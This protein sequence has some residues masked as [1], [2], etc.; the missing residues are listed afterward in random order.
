MASIEKQ[1]EY[2]RR[3]REKNREYLRQYQRDWTAAHPEARR[4]KQLRLYNLTPEVYDEML[5]RQGYLCA[6]C[7]GAPT[8]RD[9]FFVDHDHVTGKV[10]GLLCHHCNVSIGM[11]KDDPAV[12]EKLAAY[13]RSHKE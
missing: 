6:G 2:Q 7:G 8:A 1:R 9:K 4:K 11:A 3:F 5:A 12:L 10:R 13:L